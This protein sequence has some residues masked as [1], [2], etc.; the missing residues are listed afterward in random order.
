MSKLI[1]LF[2]I[3]M[4][5]LGCGVE[6]DPRTVWD[7]HVG[8]R[9]LEKGSFTDAQKDFL[10]AL[11]IDP[12]IGEL[13]VNLG[14]TYQ[15]L[16]QGDAAIQSYQSA[17]KWARNPGVSFVSRFNQGVLHGENKK[18]DEALDD[19]QRSLEIRPDSLEAKTNIELL[20]AAQKGDGQGEG[21]DQD[22]KDDQ[23]KDDK[24]KKGK[25]Q[26]QD[27]DNQDQNKKDDQGNS[28]QQKSP[29][30]PKGDKQYKPREFKGD[31]SEQ[32]VKKIL[33]ELKQQE[34]KIRGQFYRG[35]VKEKPR[36]KD[37]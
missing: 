36:D 27:K 19:Y 14:L 16:Q 33:G 23:K 2:V 8:S 25:G 10:R 12:F 31:L 1:L 32:N 6:V 18:V 15:A 5:L 28:D 11:S 26:G 3:A 4:S 21:K 30:N 29:P 37:W 34:Q 17:E 7:N 22:K 9:E 13:H 20:I 24:D 35:D